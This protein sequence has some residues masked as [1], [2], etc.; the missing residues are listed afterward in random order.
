M[1]Q[2]KQLIIEHNLEYIHS[3]SLAVCDLVAQGT[4]LKTALSLQKLNAG[5]FYRTRRDTPDVAKAWKEAQ[6]I[7]ADIKLSDLSE[8][9]TQLI[10]EEGL[11]TN[12]YNAVTKNERWIVEKLAP[13]AYGPRPTQQT[14]SLV[15][16]VQ[17]LHTLTDEQIL[18]IANGTASLPEP[19]QQKDKKVLD[20][21]IEAEYTEIGSGE[22]IVFSPIKD[23]ITEFPF[24]NPATDLIQSTTNNPDSVKPAG[25]PVSQKYDLSAFGDFS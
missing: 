6:E 8:M 14:N 18:A 25:E 4:N 22:D 17:I 19:V 2:E 11:T 23:Q 1:E 16:N 15:Q 3:K 24:D 7:L 5:D 21:P 9:G 20:K 10:N 12:T 13:S